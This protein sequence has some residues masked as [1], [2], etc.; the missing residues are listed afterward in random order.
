MTEEAMRGYPVFRVWRADPDRLRAA[1]LRA[2]RRGQR[3]RGNIAAYC[4]PTASEW[5]DRQVTLALRYHQRRGAITWSREHGWRM[6]CD[7]R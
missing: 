7:V 5:S 4:D 6:V 1:V 3:T 2:I